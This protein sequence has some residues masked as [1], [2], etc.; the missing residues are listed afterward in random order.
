MMLDSSSSSAF[1]RFLFNLFSRSAFQKPL[2]LNRAGLQMKGFWKPP[3]GRS[4]NSAGSRSSA[5]TFQ[6]QP[7]RGVRRNSCFAVS[8]FPWDSCISCG[9][10]QIVRIP[11]VLREPCFSAPRPTTEMEASTHFWAKAFSTSPLQAVFTSSPK[12]TVSR[13]RR[14]GS[15][16]VAFLSNY[17]EQTSLQWPSGDSLKPHIIDSRGSQCDSTSEPPG[18]FQNM[19]VPRPSPRP[20]N[21][22]L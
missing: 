15:H 9:Y 10:D 22:N 5:G 3:V 4:L 21:Q 8:G 2:S 17:S 11:C 1:F 14:D 12:P 18:H 20:R 16:W 6:D 7:Q 13:Q 19:P